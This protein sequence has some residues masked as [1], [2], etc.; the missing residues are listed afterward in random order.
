MSDG[1]L[2]SYVV[3][4]SSAERI[5]SFRKVDG[6]QEKAFTCHDF[7]MSFLYSLQ[8]RGYRFQ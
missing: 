5:A 8:E 1:R 4:I 6:Y 3:W 2:E 7:F